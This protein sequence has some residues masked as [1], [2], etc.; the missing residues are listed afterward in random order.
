MIKNYTI[1]RKF[2]IVDYWWNEYNLQ[3]G[4]VVTKSWL[5]SSLMVIDREL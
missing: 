1:T 5:S 2:H 4:S 3:T